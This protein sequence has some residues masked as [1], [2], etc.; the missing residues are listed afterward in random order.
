MISV[1]SFVAF[2]GSN[3]TDLFQRKC[4]LSISW[5]QRILRLTLT[6]VVFWRTL[7]GSTSMSPTPTAYQ[8]ATYFQHCR[9]PLNYFQSL[10]S[11]FEGVTTH[12]FRCQYGKNWVRIKQQLTQ[13]GRCWWSQSS[14][15]ALW[16]S[17]HT[18]KKQFTSS[19]FLKNHLFT[20]LS[21][22]ANVW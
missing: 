19:I 17:S 4:L 14:K 3:Q 13:T 7:A 1:Q 16:R 8:K 6:V 20:T 21:R 2:F 15:N 10:K 22:S 9:A 18:R 5:A 11:L 12:S